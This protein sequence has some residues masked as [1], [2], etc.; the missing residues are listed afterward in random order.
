MIGF[1]EPRRRLRR[2]VGLHARVLL[3]DFHGDAADLSAKLLQRKIEPHFLLLAERGD[4]PAERREET[5]AYLFRLLRPC[6]GM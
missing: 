4:R 2:R 5:E 6:R 3:E 1:D